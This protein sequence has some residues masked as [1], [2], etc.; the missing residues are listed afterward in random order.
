MGGGVRGG[1][2]LQ[3]HGEWWLY[4][5]V[6]QWPTGD[7]GMSENNSKEVQYGPRFFL[8]PSHSEPRVWDEKKMPY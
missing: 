8:I 1:K 6:F 7:A 5:A 2:G 3:P 4:L